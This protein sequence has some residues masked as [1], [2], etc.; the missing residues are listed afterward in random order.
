M[1]LQFIRSRL[2]AMEAEFMAAEDSLLAIKR[3]Q[4][5]LQDEEIEEPGGEVARLERQ[6]DTKGTLYMSMLSRYEG[7][8]IK[9]NRRFPKLEVLNYASAEDA[10]PASQTV[11]QW[12]IISSGVGLV[13]SIFLAFF[14]EFLKKNHDSGRLEPIL[15]VLR[16]DV[17]RIRGLFR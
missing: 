16:K 4:R 5:K 2:K 11:R 15:L 6:V 13:L 8:R 14:L 3:R 10:T 17:D 7:V 9:A 1:D 12:V